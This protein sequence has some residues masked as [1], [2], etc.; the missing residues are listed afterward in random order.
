M[1]INYSVSGELNINGSPVKTTFIVKNLSTGFVSREYES[2]V[3]Y[4]NINLANFPNNTFDKDDIIVFYFY[5]RYNGTQYKAYMYDVINP[6]IDT[7]NINVTLVSDWNYNSEIKID[8]IGSNRSVK[9]LTNEY[10]HILFKL[11]IK[12]KNI[13]REI[14]SALIDK[15]IINL[16]FNHNGEFKIIGYVVKDNKLLTYSEKEFEISKVTKESTQLQYI[17]WE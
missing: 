12:Y 17:E 11:Y 4:Y 5:V 3:G 6:K 16:S 13:Y 1:L 10:E 9:F 2:E 8:G 15:Q 14:D 7:R